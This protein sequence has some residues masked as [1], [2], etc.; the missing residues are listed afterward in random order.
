MPVDQAKL[1]HALRDA[2]AAT[3]IPSMPAGVAPHEILGFVWPPVA[4]DPAA[5]ENAYS[6]SNPTG[7]FVAAEAFAA[8]VDAVPVASPVYATNGQSTDALYGMLVRGHAIS[9]ATASPA[10]RDATQRAIAMLRTPSEFARYANAISDARAADMRSVAAALSSGRLPAADHATSSLSAPLALRALESAGGDAVDGLF[11]AARETYEET[12]LASVV[13]PG[14]TYHACEAYPA[15]WFAPS[16]STVPLTIDSAQI[17]GLALAIDRDVRAKFTRLI[18]RPTTAI[19]TAIADKTATA[20]TS[21]VLQVDVARVD[22]RRPWLTST[23]FSLP[24]YRV[25]GVP[26]GWFS[27]GK[28]D[29]T[30]SGQLPVVTTAFVV[31]RNLQI[32]A[33]GDAAPVTVDHGLHL[34]AWIGEVVPLSAPA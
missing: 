2:L 27:T 14:I 28:P 13:E 26:P 31:M 7:S 20:S 18:S 10:V 1:L 3:T 29:M 25:E 23:L 15:D 24:G 11:S 21:V 32:R 8:F 4:I 9:R 17:D 16:A 6:P 30:N 22:L 19:T 5:F 33:D 12:R 34:V